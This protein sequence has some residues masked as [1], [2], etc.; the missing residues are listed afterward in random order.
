MFS[1]SDLEMGPQIGKSVLRSIPYERRNHERGSADLECLRVTFGDVAES[2]RQKV[3][4][5]LE[6]YCA[7]DTEGWLRL[8]ESFKS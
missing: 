2:E 8:I 7:L 3:R 4:K 5:Q 1:V 6:E